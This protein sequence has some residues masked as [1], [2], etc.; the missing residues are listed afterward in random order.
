MRTPL[1]III[2]I[3]FFSSLILLMLSGFI[4]SGIRN[5]SA[6]LATLIIVLV[7]LYPTN[8]IGSYIAGR[9]LKCRNPQCTYKSV[10]IL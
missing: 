9:T 2:A 6:P 8:L 1:I 7:H 5:N 4:S 3:A 10:L